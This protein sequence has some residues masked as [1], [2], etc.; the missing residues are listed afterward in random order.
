[1]KYIKVQWIHDF[2]DEP[3]WIYCELN[4]DSW[5]TRKV[6]VFPDGTMGFASQAESA[7]TTELSVGPIPPI[8]EIAADPQFDPVEI[9]PQEF[10]DVW[11]RRSA[12]PH[13]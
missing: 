7:G 8:P 9:A 5:E 11:A 12:R 4:D 1:M 6:E 10:E 2:P 3:A 13:R